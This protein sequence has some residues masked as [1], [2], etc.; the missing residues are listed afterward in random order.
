[1]NFNL[2]LDY[3]NNKGKQRISMSK[4][5]EAI[6]VMKKI[7]DGGID[8]LH[9]KDGI[10]HKK[11]ENDD[12]SSISNQDKEFHDGF[13]NEEEKELKKKKQIEENFRLH[14]SLDC[15][16]LL[17]EFRKL[18]AQKPTSDYED[19]AAAII[20]KLFKGKNGKGNIFDKLQV[21]K[22]QRKNFF[23][24]FIENK[25]KYTSKN[26]K[27]NI[28]QEKESYGNFDN[29]DGIT[30]KEFISKTKNGSDNFNEL[31]KSKNMSFSNGE[32]VNNNMNKD[33]DDNSDD[34]IFTNYIKSRLDNKDPCDISVKK[35]DKYKSLF[36]AF[37]ET[38]KCLNNVDSSVISGNTGNNT[39]STGFSVNN[40]NSVFNPNTTRYNFNE[41]FNNYYNKTNNDWNKNN[42]LLGNIS[43]NNQ[44]NKIMFSDGKSNL[45]NFIKGINKNNFDKSQD[46]FSKTNYDSSHNFRINSVNKKIKLPDPQYNFN[47][48]AKY[49]GE[50]ENSEKNKNKKYESF[51]LPL[52]KKNDNN[53]DND[54]VPKNLLIELKQQRGDL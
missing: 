5:Q 15:R 13:L 6:E 36:L 29:S 20:E 25:D 37:E 17:E 30:N 44:T 32:K 43:K 51:L 42:K 22:N 4:I 26:T 8:N 16:K 24:K 19:N 27:Q 11:D 21:N 50:E 53:A 35:Y 45:N 23:E 14:D 52:L 38:K 33:K 1:M 34:M 48:K 10:N 46:K 3:F 40:R 28:Q 31:N 2:L 49:F 7:I 9:I 54:F 39:K 12:H 18:F 41:K 47:Y